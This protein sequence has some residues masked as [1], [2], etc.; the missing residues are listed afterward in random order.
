M[1]LIWESYL[2][3]DKQKG[4]DGKACWKG[5]K[6][7]GT[8][9]KG[10]KTV[11]NCVKIKNES[12]FDPSYIL[13]FAMNQM[14]QGG[15]DLRTIRRTLMSISNDTQQKEYLASDQFVND[16]ESKLDLSD[17]DMDIYGEDIYSDVIF[18]VDLY[19]GN[20]QQLLMT[21]EIQEALDHYEQQGGK[22]TGGATV[23]M[24]EE[25]LFLKPNE[26]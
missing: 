6:R 7:M 25:E 1:Q 20:S 2:T 10:G 4:V 23:W 17:Q 3:E 11:D 24:G 22:K 18:R 8:K 15:A 16:L 13:D 9:K 5:Y 14:Q 19:N 12:S 26:Q 21:P